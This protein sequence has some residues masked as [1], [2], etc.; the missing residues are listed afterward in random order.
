MSGL[1]PIEVARLFDAIPLEELLR[2]LDEAE[3]HA[4][5]RRAVVAEGRLAAIR[6]EVI[7]EL[8]SEIDELA[9]AAREAAV[10]GDESRYR[11]LIAP[12]RARQ[13]VQVEMA[14]A[15][16]RAHRAFDPEAAQATLARA[17]ALLEADDDPA[18]QH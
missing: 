2:G 13:R 1:R 18:G 16:L 12:L 10:R 6:Q 8:E 17:R 15:W 11:T 14:D 3:S 4:R 7:L 9:C 5:R